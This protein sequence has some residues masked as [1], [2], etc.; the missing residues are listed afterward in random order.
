MMKYLIPIAIL[1]IMAG[2]AIGTMWLYNDPTFFQMGTP[3]HSAIFKP[4]NTPAL[5]IVDA[6]YFPLLGEGFYND[7][8]P[9]SFANKTSTIYISSK[10]PS[11]HP[12]ASVTF[13]GHL[14]NNMK[15]AQSKSSLKVGPQ[16]SWTTLNTS[17]AL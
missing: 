10:S 7:A 4:A 5:E 9:V 1:F 11:A 16:G 12:P 14:E 8:I 15:Y 6:P 3:T 17:G 2:S 13:G